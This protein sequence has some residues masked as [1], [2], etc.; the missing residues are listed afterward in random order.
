MKIT[1]TLIDH[2][3][4]VSGVFDRLGIGK[5]IDSR[6]RKSRHHKVPHSSATK[7]MVL[8]GLGFLGQRLYL[9]PDYYYKVPVSKLIG[10][11]IPPSHLKDKVHDAT[12]DAIYHNGTTDMFNEIVLATM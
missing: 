4:L 11:D 1:S 12:F 10:A 2:L 8:N 7:A 5:V 9:Y 3:G 6:L